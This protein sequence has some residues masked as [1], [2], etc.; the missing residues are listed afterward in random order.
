MRPGVVAQLNLA[1]FDQRPQQCQV[2]G[3]RAVCAVDEIGQPH[4]GI[5]GELCVEAHHV[6]V[7]AVINGQCQQIA[8][9]RQLV[10]HAATGQRHPLDGRG[11]R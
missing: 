8:V 11:L 10:E 6:G 5:F 7:H 9:P 1:G 2:V 3:P 4:A